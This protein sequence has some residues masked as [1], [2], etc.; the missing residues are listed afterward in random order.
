[1]LI[2]LYINGTSTNIVRRRDEELSAFLESDGRTVRIVADFAF[3]LLSN[4][5]ISNKKGKWEKI[6]SSEKNIELFSKPFVDSR[7]DM[8]KEITRGLNWK[9]WEEKDNKDGKYIHLHNKLLGLSLQKAISDSD[10]SWIRRF[11]ALQELYRKTMKK[12]DSDN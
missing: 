3:A 2:S 12:D 4:G 8:V 5:Y 1:M 10:P 9:E 7:Y 6:F 11:E